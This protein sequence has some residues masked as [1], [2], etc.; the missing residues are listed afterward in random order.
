MIHGTTSYSG[1][2]G[3]VN[4]FR[5]AEYGRY[6]SY[7]MFMHS[8]EIN[9]FHFW[10]KTL[11]SVFFKVSLNN[12]SAIHTIYQLSWQTDT[13]QEHQAVTRRNA[14][15]IHWLVYASQASRDNLL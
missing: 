7:N 9:C 4:T 8:T 13:V 6:F 10:I 14:H 1:D 11:L 15:R 2:S 3:S 5:P 12:I